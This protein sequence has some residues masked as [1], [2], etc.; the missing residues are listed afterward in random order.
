[1]KREVKPPRDSWRGLAF[2]DLKFKLKERLLNMTNLCTESKLLISTRPKVKLKFII[3][4]YASGFDDWRSYIEHVQSE[5]SL[6]DIIL[7]RL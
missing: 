2:S 4:V 1:M 5:N 6:E 7:E 3:L